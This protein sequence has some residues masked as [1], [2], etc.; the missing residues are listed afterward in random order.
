MR[1]TSPKTVGFKSDGKTL[2]WSPKNYSKEYPTFQL[3]CGK[4]I[5]C[6]LEYARQWAQRCVHEASMFDD[7]SFI[8]LTY[9]PENLVSDKLIYKDFQDFMKRLRAKNPHLE[10]GVFVT[11]E[12]GDEKKRPHWHALLFNYRPHDAVHKYTSDRGDKV[13]SSEE[14]ASLWPHGTSELGQVTFESAGYC[15]RYAAKKLV[16]GNDQ[17]HDYQ[18][19]SKK[20]SKHAIGKRWL[21]KHW[22]DVFNHGYI[23]NA[24]GVKSGVP[25]YYEKWLKRERPGHW[26]HYRTKIKEELLQKIIKEEE[27]IKADEFDINWLRLN[28]GKPF[29]IS[30][31]ETR[32]QILKQKFDELQK[33]LKL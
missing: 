6:R 14:L 31:N 16:H 1:C 18:P 9:S 29:Q 5:S 27:V 15:A 7:N 25:R 21:E 33:L 23:I 26:R 12:Y 17:D 28:Q 30:R 20:S 32:N 24:E 22:Q 8:T 13:Y 11:G 19:I 4:C 2:C 10:I 3:P